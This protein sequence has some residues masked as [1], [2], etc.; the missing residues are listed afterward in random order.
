MYFSELGEVHDSREQPGESSL[1][2]V[3]DGYRKVTNEMTA[4]ESTLY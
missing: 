3:P 4:Q 2:V 1:Y